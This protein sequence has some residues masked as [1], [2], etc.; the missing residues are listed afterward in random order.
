MAGQEEGLQRAWRQNGKLYVNYEA[1]HG[2]IFGLKRASLC[3]ELNDENIVTN[4]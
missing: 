4:D 1:K 3:Y 2:R